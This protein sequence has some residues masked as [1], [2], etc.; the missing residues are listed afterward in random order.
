MLNNF[1]FFWVTYD[2]I[3]SYIFFRNFFLGYQEIF[4]FVSAHTND[5]HCIVSILG[6]SKSMVDI[7]ALNYSFSYLSSE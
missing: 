1:S 7:M 2:V 4:K 3:L 5:S 6:P